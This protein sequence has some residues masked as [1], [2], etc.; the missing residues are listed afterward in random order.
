MSRNSLNT[1]SACHGIMPRWLW[2]ILWK[3]EFFPLAVL[4]ASFPPE[5]S[6]RQPAPKRTWL[7]IFVSSGFVPILLFRYEL[8][9]TLH[10]HNDTENGIRNLQSPLPSFKHYHLMDNPIA[11][12]PLVSSFLAIPS[13]H[14]LEGNLTF[15]SLIPNKRIAF[16]RPYHNTTIPGKK[17]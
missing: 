5:G 10:R 3:E 17:S 12:K 6:W 4:G 9:T 7:S 1:G 8:W 16:N 2:K 14:Y 15:Y 11:S 13:P